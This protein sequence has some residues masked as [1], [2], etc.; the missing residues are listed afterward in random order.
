MKHTL[1]R[2]FRAFAILSILLTLF[3]FPV[4]AA[5]PGQGDQPQPP[6]VP[7]EV[8][9]LIPVVTGWIGTKFIDFLKQVFGWT[10]PADKRKNVW[11]SLGVSAALAILLLLIT[12]SF[13]PLT[14]PNTFIAWISVAF[15]TATLI[16]KSMQP[17]P[18]SPPTNG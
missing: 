18:E 5:A 14:G 15:T 1:F 11:L 17:A 12:G 10:T 7:D 3:V 16:Y 13:V 8:L 4:L 2:T 9:L 6:K